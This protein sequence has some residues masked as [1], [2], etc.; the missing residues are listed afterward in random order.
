MCSSDLILVRSGYGRGE[1]DYIGLHEALQPD[2]R[3][4]DLA[5]AV[6]WILADLTRQTGYKE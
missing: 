6:A 2:M 4:E 3:A 5:E 1:E